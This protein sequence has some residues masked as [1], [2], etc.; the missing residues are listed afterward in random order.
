MV[1]QTNGN[2]FREEEIVILD[3]FRD[4]KWVKNIFPKIYRMSR[5]SSVQG[6]LSKGSRRFTHCSVA[7]A[8]SW[9]RGG[10]ARLEAGK[11]KGKG[12]K[13]GLAVLEALLFFLVELDGIEPTASWMPFMRSPN[14]A[15]APTFSTC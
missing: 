11:G 8:L 6:R 10:V 3:Q 12:N 14:W 9:G 13:K 15:T 4:G 5:W 2:Q 1:N 7:F